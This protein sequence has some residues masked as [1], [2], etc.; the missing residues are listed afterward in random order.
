M[1]DMAGDERDFPADETRDK[2]RFDYPV[3]IIDREDL[4]SGVYGPIANDTEL[5]RWLVVDLAYLNKDKDHGQEDI[6]LEAPTVDELIELWEPTD[7]LIVPLV[8]PDYSDTEEH[9]DAA[10]YRDGQ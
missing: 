8:A 6:G 5:R 10:L 2:P 7:Y 3:V 4:E 1:A 9:P